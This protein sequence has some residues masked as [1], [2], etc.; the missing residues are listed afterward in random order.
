[1][2]RKK[3]LPDDEIVRLYKEGKSIHSIATG[4]AV[5]DGTIKKLLIRQGVEIRKKPNITDFLLKYY[6]RDYKPATEKI[7]EME[8]M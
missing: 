5:C 8:V 1:M 6:I 3:E 7:M 4:Y 2:Q